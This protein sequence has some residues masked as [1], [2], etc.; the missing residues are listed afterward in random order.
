MKCLLT[1]AQ[2][3]LGQ[4]NQSVN[5]EDAVDREKGSNETHTR[6]GLSGFSSFLLK[7]LNLVSNW[8]VGHLKCIDVQEEPLATEKV[9][10][11]LWKQIY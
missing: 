4:E 6:F 7:L 11:L 3:S 9:H 8:L 1:K 10:F 5:C 2:Q